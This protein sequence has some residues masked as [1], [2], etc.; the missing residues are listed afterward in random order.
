MQE[1]LSRRSFFRLAG[2]G[3]AAAVVAPYALAEKIKSIP[4]ELGWT[5]F[6]DKSKV[7]PTLSE[8]ISRTL[9][10]NKIK[11]ADNLF[12]NNALLVKL[13]NG[14][15]VQLNIERIDSDVQTKR[16]KD[17]LELRFAQKQ[18]KRL[19]DRL[20]NSGRLYSVDSS[21]KTI[22]DT[23]HLPYSDLEKKYGQA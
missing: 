21:N 1:K 17:R 13:K 20:N 11:I 7:D 22:E 2:G 4:V 16:M 8:L 19:R 6:I 14:Q 3:I 23:F 12:E 18:E 15:K 5:W 9:R 10:E